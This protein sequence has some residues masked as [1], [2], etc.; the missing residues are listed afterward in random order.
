MSEAFHGAVRVMKP[1]QAAWLIGLTVAALVLLSLGGES[2]REALRYERVAVLRGEYWRLLTGH[3]IHGTTQHLLLNVLGLGVIAALFPREFSVRGWLFIALAS[4]S[5][6][7]LGFVLWE[8]QLEWY[9][10]LSGV[11]HG[12]LAAGAI[13]W[14]RHE[15]KGF[16]AVLSV[17]LVGKLAWEQWR[18]ALPLSGDMPVIVD[19]HLYGAI[20][21]ALAAGALWA[22]RRGWSP[23]PRSL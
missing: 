7:D 21:G 4:M 1:A 3:L 10:G 13:G 5:V 19:A 12:L 15:S 18:G 8:P 23:R 2:W 14:W 16:A 17:V 22:L 11:L 9:V 20:G 6:I